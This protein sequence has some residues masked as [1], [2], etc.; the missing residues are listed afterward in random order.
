MSPQKTLFITTGDP[1]GIGCEVA[2][3]SLLKKKK[4][5]AKVVLI[6]HPT[7]EKKWLRL[8]RQKTKAILLTSFEEARFS[9]APFIDLC[10]KSNPAVWVKSAAQICHANPKM[11]YLLTG[12]LS[13]GLIKKSGIKAIGHTEILKN[14]SQSNSAFMYFRGSKFNVALSTAHIPIEAVTAKFSADRVI[15]LSELI[16]ALNVKLGDKRPIAVLGLNPHNGDK[17]IISKFDDMKIS[18]LIKKLTKKKLAV[19][20]PLVPDSAFTKS[21]QTI[22]SCFVCH[23][24]D[25]GLIPFKMTHEFD[26]GVHLTLGISFFRASVDH[27]P[28]FDIFGKSKA[29]IGSFL[30]ALDFTLEYM[31]RNEG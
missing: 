5:D 12:P 17:G 19:A 3:K 4:I 11:N 7:S 15:Q 13:K 25:Q 21:N 1:N 24:H 18:P 22:Y 8:Y 6:R 16:T 20:G 23:Y 9:T 31:K 27:G 29:N 2:V 28:A 26:E 10:L 14:V 30:S